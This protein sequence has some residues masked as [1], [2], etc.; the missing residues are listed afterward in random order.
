[1]GQH[2]YL[3]AWLR[4]KPW[5]FRLVYLVDIFP[6]MKEVEP[7]I[8]RKQ[9]TELVADDKMRVFK[10]KLELLKICVQEVDIV[11]TTF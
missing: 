2:F 6:K 10:Q 3:K 7:A 1:M 9:L 8:L 4:D 5:L 11:L